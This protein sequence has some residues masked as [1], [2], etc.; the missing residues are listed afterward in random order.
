MAFVPQEPGVFPF[1][2]RPKETLSLALT[3]KGIESSGYAHRFLDM[4]GLGDEDGSA[5]G[6]S[7]GM[8]H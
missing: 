1:F 4:L 3:L 5:S 6:Y 2:Q 8:K 7:T